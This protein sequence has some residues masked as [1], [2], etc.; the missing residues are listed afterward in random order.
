[1]AQT[2][3][4]SSSF[5]AKQI[6]LAVALV[7]IAG[8]LIYFLQNQDAKP[9]PESQVEEKSVASGLGNFYR[10][11]LSSSTSPEEEEQGDFVLD[12]EGVDPE[13]DSKLASMSSQT[14][15]VADSWTG[16]HKYRSFKE[17]S[18]LREVISQYAQAEGMQVIWNLE[19]DFVIKYQFQLEN[20]VAGSLANIANAIDS[21]FEGKVRVYM[22][23][24]QRS[25][26]VTATETEFLTENCQLVR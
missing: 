14:R 11:Y 15:P 26:I 23:P 12:I 22:C 16:E 8:V 3:Y 13:L 4:S 19:Q 6:G 24:N 20:T 18:T 17:G 7:L 9:V 2:G 21:N 25:L 5:W 10:D 1:M